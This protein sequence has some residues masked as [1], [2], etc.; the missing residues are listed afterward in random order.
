MAT[1]VI[2]AFNEFLKD[3]VNL[4]KDETSTARN[5]RDW[6]VDRIHEFPTNESSFP[7]L[8]STKD[9]Y[10]GSFARKTKKRE[11]DDIDIMIGLSGDGTTYNE[12][13]DRIE[14]NVPDAATNLKK[15]CN[16]NS[17]V[18]NSRKVINKFISMLEDIPQ[19][20]KSRN[21]T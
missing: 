1:T 7:K 21:E 4:D 19:Y 12:H 13:S 10:F 2:S 17:N 9:I 11:L 3:K 14:L 5:S 16:D 18:L 20:K 15:L 6:L 8:Y